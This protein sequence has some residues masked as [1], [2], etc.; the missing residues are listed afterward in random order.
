MKLLIWKFDTY[1]TCQQI[2]L[3]PNRLICY[4]FWDKISSIWLQ[5]RGQIQRIPNQNGHFHWSSIAPKRTN[6]Q[7]SPALSV[8]QS[9]IAHATR[10]RSPHFSGHLGVPSAS[11]SW[12]LIVFL[13]TQ[14]IGDQRDKQPQHTLTPTQCRSNTTQYSLLLYKKKRRA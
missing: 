4:R 9:T 5:N 6:R 14:N 12:W 7:K 10:Q 1:E 13:R 2:C 3:S 11:T 8:W